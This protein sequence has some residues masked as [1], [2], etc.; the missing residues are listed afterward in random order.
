MREARSF[1]HENISDR[2]AIIA[3]GL[4]IFTLMFNI[5]IPLKT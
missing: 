4:G 1:L 5:D 2:M 3:M